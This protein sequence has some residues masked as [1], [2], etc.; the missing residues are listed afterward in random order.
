M[1][2]RAQAVPETEDGE[3]SETDDETREDH[4]LSPPNA[5]D[6]V[7]PDESGDEGVG[8]REVSRRT[9]WEDLATRRCG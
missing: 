3:E 4:V 1:A 5:G 2:L 8:R 6:E 7:E 9:E